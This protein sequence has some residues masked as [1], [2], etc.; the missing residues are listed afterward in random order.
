MSHFRIHATS[1]VL[2]GFISLFLELALIRWLPANILSLAYF[3][4]LVL[5]SSFVGLG[6]G[7]LLPPATRDRFRFFLPVLF[8]VVGVSILMRFIQP[9]IPDIPNESLWSV[10]S[11]NADA[12][13]RI[14]LGIIPTLAVVF[15]LNATPFVLLGDVIGRLMRQFKPLTA[16]ALDIIGSLF[17]IA[18]FTMLAFF[19]EPFA[20]PTMWFAL[21][22][23]LSLWFLRAS[24]LPL[25][26][27]VVCVLALTGITWEATKG[28][29]WSPYYRIDTVYNLKG[30]STSI[31]VNQFF[32]QSMIDLETD[33]E[34]RRKY[35]FP[36]TYLKPESVLILGAGSGNDVAMAIRSGVSRIDAVE[37]DPRI[38]DIGKKGHPNRPY[39]S[40]AVRLHI[41][42]ARSFL[43][44]NKEVYDM[45]VMGTLDSHA[46]LS[47]RSTVRLDNF[48]YTQESLRA[49]SEH[50]TE[51]GVAVLLFSVPHAW[52]GDKIV[53]SVQN[54][55]GSGRVVVFTGS[56]YLFN[57]VI[58][59]GPGVEELL[60]KHPDT[61]VAS[62]PVPSLRISER[63]I[64]TD[65]WPYLYLKEPGISAHYRYAIAVLLIASL[66]ALFALLRR[67]LTEFLTFESG[68]FFFLG[69]GFLLLET[70]SITTLSL[71]FGST[72]IVH[73]FVFGGILSMVLLAN[74]LV[75]RVSVPLTFIYAGLGAAILVNYFVPVAAFLTLPFWSG[76]LL[77]SLFVASPIFF[78][79][80]A[81]SSHFKAVSDIRLMYGLNLMGLVCGGFLEYTA[82]LTGMRAL[83][84]LAVGVY[85]LAFALY[86]YASRG[87]R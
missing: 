80:M 2:A 79:S 74:L 73:S 64:S 55:Y 35:E 78:A 14:S 4:N 81:F 84:L 65:D 68:I 58:F 49:V 41:D 22:G 77:A 10:Y 82:M 29:I 27:G 19:G 83:Y 25:A 60:Q 34:A 87:T 63:G 15:V 3:S 24:R 67:R 32:F 18:L 53:K 31:L 26:V 71:V 13:A 54:V 69:V 47:A 5:I 52:L 20:S 62:T 59:A 45:V 43:A 39:D 75:A 86:W 6:I 12:L 51:K 1:L 9:V 28:E 17:G 8:C 11:G 37:I 85:T 66:A 38:A 44:K 30:N 42:D 40:S 72:W 48:V 70:K 16:Y 23:I 7:F 76:A 61:F 33:D 21:T 57:L 46:L 50:L 56:K 36:Y